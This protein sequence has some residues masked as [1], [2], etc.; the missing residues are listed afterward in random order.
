MRKFVLP[1]M[2]MFVLASEIVDQAAAEQSVANMTLEELQAY[3]RSGNQSQAEKVPQQNPT[4][5]QAADDPRPESVVPNSGKSERISALLVS[6]SS[7]NNSDLR[8]S[9]REFIGAILPLGPIDSDVVPILVKILA[10]PPSFIGDERLIVMALGNIGPSAK[11]AIPLLLHLLGRKDKADIH[12]MV[13]TTLG[14]IG[15]VNKRITSSLASSL[16]SGN[17]CAAGALKELTGGPSV[18]SAGVPDAQSS[19]LIKDL[20]EMGDRIGSVTS[21]RISKT[22]LPREKYLWGHSESPEGIFRGAVMNGTLTALMQEEDALIRSIVSKGQPGTVAD[23]TGLVH[24]LGRAH[25]TV[26]IVNEYAGILRQYGTNISD[27]KAVIT[28]CEVSD[29][30]QSNIV[31]AMASLGPNAIPALVKGLGGNA[32]KEDGENLKAQVLTRMGSTAVPALI[33]ALTNSRS[34]YMAAVALGNMG[35]EAKQAIPA[36]TR[37]LKDS[38]MR[39]A[40]ADALKKIGTTPEVEA[41]LRDGE[42]MTRAESERGK[43]AAADAVLKEAAACMVAEGKMQAEQQSLQKLAAATD[44][45]RVCGQFSA[46]YGNFQNQY[47][48]DDSYLWQYCEK[49]YQTRICS[50]LRFWLQNHR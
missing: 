22:E 32:M 25:Y 21:E 35:P 7:P 11:P 47:G 29:Q 41:A 10:N 5:P 14:H 26:R 24:A 45:L 17:K 20:K 44:G 8:Q 39:E 3:L 16:R 9:Q 13:A 27:N 6:A 37:L 28:L 36:L 30:V 48:N 43:P 46:Y 15:F 23:A 38:I 19:A 50:S 33:D 49:K 34:D 1:V 18:A 12:C 2:V 31:Q 4:T 42:S 40:A